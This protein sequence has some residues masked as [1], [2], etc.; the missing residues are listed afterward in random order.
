M[1]YS[2]IFFL[3]FSSHRLN[4]WRR[5]GLEGYERSAVVPMASTACAACRQLER[6]NEIYIYV[7]VGGST[8]KLSI[9]LLCEEDHS[10]FYHVFILIFYFKCSCVMLEECMHLGPILGAS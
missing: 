10:I 1:I 2:K 8:S 6:K 4:N 7:Q 9:L 5:N 3:F